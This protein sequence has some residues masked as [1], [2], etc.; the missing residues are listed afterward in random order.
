MVH[1]IGR[2]VDTEHHRFGDVAV[3][4]RTNAESRV[5]EERS[6]APACRTASWAA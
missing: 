1:E 6:C 3:F 4:Y 5:I 2:L